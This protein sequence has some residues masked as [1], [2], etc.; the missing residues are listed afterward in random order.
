M[1]ARTAMGFRS[2]RRGC[3]RWRCGGRYPYSS[4]RVSFA[5][6]FLASCRCLAEHRES[7]VI[8]ARAWCGVKVYLFLNIESPLSSRVWFFVCSWSGNQ[9]ARASNIR[10]RRLQRG[11]SPREHFADAGRKAGA[12]RL[13]TG[14]TTSSCSQSRARAK[15]SYGGR[16]HRQKAA[17]VPGIFCLAVV[18]YNLTLLKLETRFWGQNYFDL[19]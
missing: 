19:V 2:T 8:A 9:G 4:T 11:P 12:D 6:G 15:L 17:F 5:Y 1:V 18:C 10:R 3:K 16:L 7:V 13:R 14:E